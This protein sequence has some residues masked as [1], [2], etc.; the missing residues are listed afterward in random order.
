MRTL[1][2]IVLPYPLTTLLMSTRSQFS[3]ILDQEWCYQVRTGIFCCQNMNV[4]RFRHAG[5]QNLMP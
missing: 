4:D 3:T 5:W 2:T 1:C